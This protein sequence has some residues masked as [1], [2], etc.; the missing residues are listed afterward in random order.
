[1]EQVLSAVTADLRDGIEAVRK[2]VNL[3]DGFNTESFSK[4]DIG[5]ANYL[6]VLKTGAI[7]DVEAPAGMIPGVLPSV[8]VAFPP[9]P[10][11]G[12]PR[13]V[14]SEFGEVW[15]LLGKKLDQGFVIIG[16]SQHSSILDPDDRLVANLRLFGS[17][18]SDAVKR[19][20]DRS[21]L[22]NAV[23]FVV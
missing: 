17:T 14:K 11:F 21:A 9:E 1:K 8:E 13:I 22:D 7:I 23:D 2:A 12:R 16:I 3:A 6:V 18:L 19:T 15:H 10:V 5:A 4:A 20:R